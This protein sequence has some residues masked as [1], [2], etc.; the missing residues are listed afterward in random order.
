MKRTVC[1]LCLFVFLLT[2][3]SCQGSGQMDASAGSS[4]AVQ[5]ECTHPE[6]KLGGNPKYLYGTCCEDDIEIYLTC[7]RCGADVFRGTM[8]SEIKCGVRD[9]DEEVI[10]ESTCT[11]KGMV[12][13]P[14]SICGTVK[15]WEL[16]LE[17]HVYHWF[18]QENAPRCINCG[19]VQDVCAHEYEQTSDKANTDSAPGQ[20]TYKCTLCEDSYSI[21]Y[22]TYG[23]YDLQTV[24]D[25]ICTLAQSYGWSV[26]SNCDLN[27]GSEIA[28]VSDSL[29]YRST[30]SKEATQ[31]LIDAGTNLL[32]TL[33]EQFFDPNNDRSDYYLSVTV[34]CGGS[35]SRGRSFE[36]DLYVRSED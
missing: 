20:R 26:I 30:D 13:G 9:N 1:C 2:L 36:I 17:E 32:T 14:C 5:T 34:D 23:D 10:R 29:P 35:A 25:T 12:Q 7:Q 4:D 6:E 3:S 8:E 19:L 24:Y 31:R 18:Y 11:E 15:Q 27:I 21:Y 22:D 33:N 16:P 28:H